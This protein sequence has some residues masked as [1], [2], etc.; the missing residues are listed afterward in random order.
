V[1]LAQAA[2]VDRAL[3]EKGWKLTTILNTHHHSDHVGG[4]LVRC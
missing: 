2:A 3:R 4:N 1:P